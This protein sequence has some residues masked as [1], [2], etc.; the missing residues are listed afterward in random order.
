MPSVEL[1]SQ[2]RV[3]RGPLCVAPPLASLM[4]AEIPGGGRRDG[5]KVLIILTEED[6]EEK[7]WRLA[8]CG[9]VVRQALLGGRNALC[10]SSECY[11]AAPK[12][13]WSVEMNLRM[14]LCL[15]SVPS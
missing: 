13:L 12:L 6:G 8:G 4:P 14:V 10:M 9:V 2:R 7:R 1:L 5:T 3:V 15:L 11:Y